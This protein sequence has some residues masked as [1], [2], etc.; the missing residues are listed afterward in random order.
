MLFLI[1]GNLFKTKN[2]IFNHPYYCRFLFFFFEMLENLSLILWFTLVTFILSIVLYPFYI[3]FLKRIK[4]WKTIRDNSATGEKSLIFTSIHKHKEWTPTMWWGLFLLLMAIMIGISLVLQKLWYTNYSLRNQ[5]ETYIILFWFFSMGI[6]GLIDDILNIKNFWTIKW[7]SMRSKILWMIIF[8][9][10]IT[11][12]F[13]IKLW[14]D[15][16]NFWP[17]GGLVHLGIF[18]PIL[19]FLWTIIIVNAVNITDWLDGLAW[20]MVAIILGWLAIVTFLNQTYLVTTILGIAIAILLAFLF[21]NINP[22]KVFMGD[23]WAFCLWWLI[24]STICLINMRIWIWIFIP[25]IILFLIF[26]IELWSSWIQML[27]KKLFKKKVFPIAPFHHYLEYKWHH[28]YEIT[29]KFWLIQWI[30][31]MIFIILIFCQ[32]W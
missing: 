10:I 15:Y 32:D 14:V 2:S 20:W 19:V 27:W 8:S 26:I 9:A 12:W 16:I 31:V 29:M 7:L 5:K 17:F 22:A 28:E 25:F 30:L 11:Y 21:F 23:S 13:Y 6:I 1:L 18:F 3:Q 4:A 24:S